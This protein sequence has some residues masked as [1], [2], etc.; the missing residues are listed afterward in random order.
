MDVAAPARSVTE[1]SDP[2]TPPRPAGPCAFVIFGAGGD[3]T[4]R[5]LTPALYNLAAAHL[6]PDEFAVI[7]VARGDLSDDAF[8][9]AMGDAL[10]EFATTQVSPEVVRDLTARFSYVRGDFDDPNTYRRLGEKLSA[11]ERTRHTGGNCLFYLATPPTVFALVAGR[12][13]EAGLLREQERRW[14]RLVVEK[15]FGTDLESAF[16]LN[17]RLLGLMTESQIYRIDHYL[18]KETVQ[19]IMVLRFANGLFEPL[20]NR[21]HI[22]HV[23]ITVAE[24]VTVENRGRFY[25]RTGTLRDMVPNHLFQLLALTAMEPPA[26][27][28]ADA[29]RGEKAK[30]VEAIR[31]FTPDDVCADV[32]RAQYRAGTIA[33]RRVPA[34]REEPGVD[35][36]SM[37][38]T[39]VAIR[40]AI[41]NW[42]WAGVPFYLRTGKA[43]A[44]RRTEIAVKFKA[45]PFALFRR[46]PVERLAQ[47]L[48]VL[49]IQPDEGAS[50]QFNAKT[51]GPEIYIGGVRMDFKYADYFEAAPNTGYETL[52]YDCMIGDATLFQRADN[53]ESGWRAVQPILDAW[54]EGRDCA[55]LTWYAGGSDGPQAAEDLLARDGRAWRKIG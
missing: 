19:N 7:G 13:A 26:H 40:L 41:D 42:R 32:V 23:Q 3:L 46:T 12:L 52:I 44:G 2:Q 47:N 29:V 53:I 51:P 31:P 9:A 24:T 39:Y 54:R 28:H 14:R 34:Y 22:D 43:L 18:G 49:R 16:E 33:G 35:P 6:L 30:A 5:L 1:S 20:W 17:R 21:D 48:L 4:K 55:D 8:R 11:A 36:N 25:D 15:P 27:F 50:L 38:E 10:R 37:T 45:A